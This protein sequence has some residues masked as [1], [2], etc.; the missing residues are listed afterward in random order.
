MK[1]FCW[2]ASYIAK[3]EELRKEELR[4][5]YLES[6][7]A[8]FNF[9]VATLWTV[10]AMASG[11]IVSFFLSTG[12]TDVADAM[13]AARC[14]GMF[15]FVCTIRF[16]MMMLG[17]VGLQRS[18]VN[19]AMRRVDNYLGLDSDSVKKKARRM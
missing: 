10:L 13:T 12:S 6:M 18:A 16:P 1:Y 15:S 14:F 9:I 3:I 4:L 2:E 17:Q 8:M 5:A 11:L 19:V 7:M